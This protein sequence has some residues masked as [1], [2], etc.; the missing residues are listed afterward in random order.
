MYKNITTEA[1]FKHI[2]FDD[3]SKT[4]FYYIVITSYNGSSYDINT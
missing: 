1:H 3:K 2:I 4:S